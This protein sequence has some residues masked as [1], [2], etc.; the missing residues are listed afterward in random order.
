M[1]ASP[2]L[3]LQQLPGK[4]HAVPRG[5]SPQIAAAFPMD[6]AVKYLNI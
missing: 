1:G 2:A 6:D 5:D 3:K 4:R